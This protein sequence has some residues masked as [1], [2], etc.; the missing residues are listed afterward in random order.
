MN[1][2]I[3][4]RFEK[5]TLKLKNKP[6]QTDIAELIE[7][8][9]A[10][11]NVHEIKGLKRLKGAKAHRIRMGDYRIGILIEDEETVEFISVGHR[12]EFYRSFP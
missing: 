1:T 4:E 12:K 11:D 8:F 9:Q 5:E 7:A 3:N 6:L 10:L 2:I